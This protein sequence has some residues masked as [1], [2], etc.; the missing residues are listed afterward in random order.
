MLAERRPELAGPVVL[1]L[2]GP[3][4]AALHRRQRVVG[5]LPGPLQHLFDGVPGDGL[6]VAEPGRFTGVVGG[7]V[8]RV[9]DRPNLWK[10]GYPAR[11]ARTSRPRRVS[12]RHTSRTLEDGNDARL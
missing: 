5:L 12:I 11:L 10:L 6:G 7:T 2:G 9:A 4:L 3:Q 1:Y 8:L